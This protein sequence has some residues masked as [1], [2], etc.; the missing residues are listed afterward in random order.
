MITDK[1]VMSTPYAATKVYSVTR[2]HYQIIDKGTVSE[3][4]T[5]AATGIHA[6]PV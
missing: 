3:G 5:A 2:C 4:H 1:I 6:L